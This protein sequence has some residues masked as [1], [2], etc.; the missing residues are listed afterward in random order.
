MKKVT[1]LLLAI[2]WSWGLYAQA[3]QSINY[4]AVARD[5]SGQPLAGVNLGLKFSFLQ[6][7]PAGT[8]VYEEAFS[9]VTNQLGLY[10]VQLGL[11]IAL[12]GSFNAID[13]ANG[14][15]FVEVG[16]DPNGGV[17]YNN[18]GTSQLISVPYALYAETVG[19]KDDA[20]A[21][22]QNEIQV[23]S[24][25]GPLISL[26][27][28]GGSVNIND[29]DSNP[30]NEIQVLSQNGNLV[31]LSNGGGS[32]TVDDADS[33]PVNELQSVTQ[34][35]DT[36]ILSNGGGSFTISDDDDDPFNELQTVAQNGASVTL[37][38][39]GG[40]FSTND[41]DADPTNEIQSLTQSG[42]TLNLS[43]GG[44]AVT[45]NVNDADSD[46]GNE[47]Q[48][49]SQTGS[50]VNLSDGGGSFS[51]NDVD[52][53]PG[54]EIQTLTQS[55]NTLNLSNG[56]GAVTLNV[57][58]ADSDPNNEYQTVSQSGSMVTLSDG[59]GSF[60]TNDEDADSTN[61][62]QTLSQAGS[63]VTLSDNGGAI[64]IDDSDADSTNEIQ[65]LTQVGDSVSLSGNGGVVS[66]ADMDAD[67]TNEL[68]QLAW[69]ANNLELSLSDGNTVQLNGIQGNGTVGP[70]QG[71]GQVT[72]FAE[73]F[74]EE[75]SDTWNNS[76]V[77]ME[78]GELKNWGNNSNNHFGIGA[79][80]TTQ[81]LP[82]WTPLDD[83]V[84][85]VVHNQYSSYWIDS[86]KDLYAAGQ[87]NVGQLGIGVT[88]AQEGYP[89]KV[90]GLSNVK[91]VVVS[92]GTTYSTSG[93][94][95]CALLE[96]GTVWCWGEGQ[97]GQLGNGSNADR[98]VPTM[99]GLAIGLNDATDIN[100]GGGYYASTCIVR[101]Y[102]SLWAWGYNAYGQLG[103]NNTNSQPAPVPVYTSSDTILKVIS[104]FDYVYQ[105]R[106]MLKADG[107]VW[108]WGYNGN[109]Q[110]GQG[111][112]ANI[113]L[114]TQVQGINSAID[115]AGGGG[116]Y[117]SV[118]VILADST[119]RCW[120]SNYRGQLGNGNTTQQNSPINPG[121]SGV[122]K[123]VVS[124][125]GNAN[126]GQGNHTVNMLK[127]D[128]TVYSIGFG[129]DGAIGNGLTAN[130][131]T[132]TKVLGISN[133]TE[134]FSG[135]ANSDAHCCVILEDGRVRCWG[136]G[137]NGQI[138]NGNNSNA[139]V[140]S[141]VK[142][143]DD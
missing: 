131:T 127:H 39:G 125:R 28:N 78:N 88:T 106:V 83:S 8:P 142:D 130:V 40:N 64:S 136:R 105:T 13:W 80:S 7:S 140:P 81:S 53:D 90:N 71:T 24:Q 87:N 22:P 38:Q 66:I 9:V 107:T 14:P 82:S 104:I 43:N 60:N 85:S 75:W 126:S 17:S 27:Q 57:N 23:I 4:Q 86:Q 55:G 137:N 118:Y 6:G 138:G 49:L 115:I 12:S 116:R 1:F 68:Q 94:S 50:T 129:A 69:N 70:Y 72:F 36:I 119:I 29:A 96:D 51:I 89:R 59:G 21:D 93:H 123:I 132:A 111:N 54:N 47:F 10:N 19:D 31:G 73:K 26:S 109:G 11:G 44:G 20:D 95:T 45:I 46:P 124:G 97:V 34:Q 102:T 33:D 65:V 91:K 37:S 101:N 110:C 134:I 76:S 84:I 117:G 18:L 25:N 92:G 58:D 16:L 48:T 120:G 32:I 63:L 128:G 139:L 99:A 98:N 121:I 108:T 103:T 114:P 35:G 61:E 135:G 113:L 62:F 52:A 100:M 141:R 15:Y 122:K 2:L 74:P 67:T 79:T 112:T 41:A 133:A 3:P 56:G 143:L 42:N 5:A 30:T 77:I